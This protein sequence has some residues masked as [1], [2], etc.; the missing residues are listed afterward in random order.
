VFFKTT[1]K[2]AIALSAGAIALFAL[3]AF[4][5]AYPFWHRLRHT[6]WQSRRKHI[7]AGRSF[8]GTCNPPAA[9]HET[10]TETSHLFEMT[11]S[12]YRN[13]RY[14]H[15]LIPRHYNGGNL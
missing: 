8:A 3:P 11:G 12:R 15:S 5:L 1:E 4:W 9:E 13:G 7:D 6:A 2:T 10:E 14:R